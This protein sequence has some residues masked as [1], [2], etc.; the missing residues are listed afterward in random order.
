MPV[1]FAKSIMTFAE[2]VARSCSYRWKFLSV[3]FA[4]KAACF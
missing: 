2:G 3:T 4:I 1:D